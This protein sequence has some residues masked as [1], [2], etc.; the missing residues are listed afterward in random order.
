V[1][2]GLSADVEVLEHAQVA[3]VRVDVLAPTVEELVELQIGGPSASMLQTQMNAKNTYVVKVVL[4]AAARV[5]HASRRSNSHTLDPSVVLADRLED[6]SAIVL[7]QA[8]EEAGAGADVVGGFLAVT[9][10]SS[11]ALVVGRELHETLLA[12]AADGVRVARRLLHG[13]RSKED[14]GD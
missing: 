14:R 7:D 10:R 6:V 4:A 9:S 5:L 13:D 8:R 2:S 12:S 1:P 11:S 3:R